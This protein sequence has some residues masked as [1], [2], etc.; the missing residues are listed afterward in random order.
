MVSKQMV[1]VVF[2]SSAFFA[3]YAHK[4]QHFKQSHFSFRG[5]DFLHSD[6]SF[7]QGIQKSNEHIEIL[8]GIENAIVLLFW[9]FETVF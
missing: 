4:V 7:K 6:Y 3:L 5:S 9:R 2:K 1:K 8:R